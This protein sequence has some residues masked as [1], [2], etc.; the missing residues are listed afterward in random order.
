M[1]VKT[2]IS[3]GRAGRREL[4]SYWSPYELLKTGEILCAVRS[5]SDHSEALVS[6]H[7]IQGIFHPPIYG[8]RPVPLKHFQLDNPLL[9]VCYFH[10]PEIF[11]PVKRS[12]APQVPVI[13]SDV[14]DYCAENGKFLA[15]IFHQPTQDVGAL[16]RKALPGCHHDFVPVAA[17]LMNRKLSHLLPHY[18]ADDWLERIIRQKPIDVK[19]VKDVLWSIFEPSKDQNDYLDLLV[20]VRT[21]LSTVYCAHHPDEGVERMNIEPVWGEGAKL[22][23]R[24]RCP[25]DR[26]LTTTFLAYCWKTGETLVYDKDDPNISFCDYPGCGCL[27]HTTYDGK[28]IGRRN[29]PRYG[30]RPLRN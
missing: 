20:K 10:P 15:A 18:L 23:L 2:T 4:K 12:L 9:N 28:R 26:H 8:S 7:H 14:I 19:A 11:F 6:E 22:I 16:L 1:D 25:T 29:C 24:A 21:I 27:T 3:V 30:E 5:S 17:E 13:D